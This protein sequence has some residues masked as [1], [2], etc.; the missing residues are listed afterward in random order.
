MFFS[1]Q[2]TDTNRVILLYVFLHTNVFLHRHKQNNYLFTIYYLK[3]LIHN[4]YNVFQQKRFFSFY[5]LYRCFT[6][7]KWF[8]DIQMFSVWPLSY[9]NKVLWSHFFFF[10]KRNATNLFRVAQHNMK[11][12]TICSGEEWDCMKMKCFTTDNWIFLFKCFMIHW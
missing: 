9:K 7:N 11:S 4:H 12:E 6:S 5:T 1:P 8:F 2:D 10:K 3:W